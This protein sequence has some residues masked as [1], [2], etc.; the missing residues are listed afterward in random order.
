M[1]LVIILLR[2]HIYET[3]FCFIPGYYEAN[4]KK[5]KKRKIWKENEFLV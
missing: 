1:I 4:N 2:I 3:W 5:I